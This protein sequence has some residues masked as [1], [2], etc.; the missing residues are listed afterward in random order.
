MRVKRLFSAV[1]AGATVVALIA[2]AVHFGSLDT[3]AHVN[4]SAHFWMPTPEQADAIVAQ[5]VAAPVRGSEFRA[6][7]FSSH[8]RNDDPIVFPGQAGVSHM[9]EFY[10]NRSANA[11]ST[12]QSLSLGTTNC[13]PVVDLSSYWTPTVYKNGQPIAP[14]RVTVYYQGITNMAAAVPHPR[15]LRYVI[16]NAGATNADQNP[17]ARW[18]CT[19]SSPSS[20]DFMNCAPGSKLETYLDFP[21]CWDGRL[22]SPNHRDHMAF[23][24]GQTCP[25][26]YPHVV[27]RLELLITYPVNGGGLT[28][29]GTR[30]GQLV[31]DQPGYTFHG[32]FFNAWDAN[33]LARRVRACINAGYICGTDGKPIQQ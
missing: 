31:T 29:A 22:D 8:R 9:H 27:P 1:A 7:C 32:D 15:G 13:D 19:G 5:Q 17:S 11:Q 20:R 25:A 18:S 2:T 24:L 21:T 16:G 28:L 3:P 4:H 14:E 6:N 30:N 23:A 33:E 12:L 10:G 26:G